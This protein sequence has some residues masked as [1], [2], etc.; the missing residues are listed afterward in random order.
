MSTFYDVLKKAENL[1]PGKPAPKTKK[2]IPLVFV[3]ILVIVVF[4][5]VFNISKVNH[6]KKIAAGKKNTAGQLSSVKTAATKPA[7]APVKKIY[8]GYELEGIIC[9][10]TNCIAVINGKILK[11][12]STI[13]DFT[14]TNISSGS[15]EL[16]S[17]KDNSVTT[18][19]L[20]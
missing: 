9:N 11:P 20:K 4:V 12:E 16:R 6:A 5:V 1:N 18:L 10:E 17:T 3:V 13:D 2:D 14:V 15:V 8:K 7:P 19:Y